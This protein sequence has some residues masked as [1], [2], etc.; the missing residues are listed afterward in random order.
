MSIIV[1]IDFLEVGTRETFLMDSCEHSREIEDNDV[2]LYTYIEVYIY[3][4][5]NYTTIL[6]L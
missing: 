1:V 4:N 2:F 3:A 6:S 5:N